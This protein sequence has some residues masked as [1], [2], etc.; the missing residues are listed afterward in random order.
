M[1]IITGMLKL[2]RLGANNMKVHLHVCQH[3]KDGVKDKKVWQGS[4]MEERQ[5]YE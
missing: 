3:Q 2:N 1:K 5:A 4:P